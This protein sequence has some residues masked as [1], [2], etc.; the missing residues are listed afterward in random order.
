MSLLCKLMSKLKTIFIKICVS[1]SRGCEKLDSLE[2]MWSRRRKEVGGIWPWDQIVKSLGWQTQDFNFHFLRSLE[3]LVEV[4]VIW[5]PCLKHWNIF[6]SRKQG[7]WTQEPSEKA[8]ILSD[9]KESL[10]ERSH[11]PLLFY[12]I[13]LRWS[14]GLKRRCAWTVP[15]LMS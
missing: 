11:H 8:A 7:V 14:N 10:G 4:P 6:D 9:P 15:L 13:S 2:Q 1:K 12:I 3:I 5:E